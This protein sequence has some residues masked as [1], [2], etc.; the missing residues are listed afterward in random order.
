MSKCKTN[1]WNAGLKLKTVLL[2]ILRK[3]RYSVFDSI[4]ENT[5][6]VANVLKPKGT[7]LFLDIGHVGNMRYMNIER[8]KEHLILPFD[9]VQ[10]NGVV[11]SFIKTRLKLKD[12]EKLFE[13]LNTELLIITRKEMG[14]TIISKETKD[15]K[16]SLIKLKFLI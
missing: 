14:S 11:A 5:L 3:N 2:M 6:K 10:I 15:I 7:K 16:S 13:T 12:D 4:K 9:V 8:L 1:L